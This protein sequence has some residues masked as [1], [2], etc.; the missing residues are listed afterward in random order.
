VKKPQQATAEDVL[1]LSVA[2]IEFYFRI[3]A[4]SAALAG[5]ANA[6]GEWGTLRTLVNDGPQTV[7]NMARSKPVSRQHCQTIVNALEA[8]GLVEFV[9]NPKHKTSRLVRVTKKGQAR[10]QSMR[11]QFLGAAGEYAHLFTASEI[12]TATDVCRR[13]RDIIEA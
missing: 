8:Q 1:D 6:G 7:P 9:D 5:F 4:I 3:D 11:K 13:G 12:A 10:F 2:V